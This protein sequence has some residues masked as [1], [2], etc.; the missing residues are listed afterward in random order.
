MIN[1]SIRVE[2][3]GQRVYYRVDSL[4]CAIQLLRVYHVFRA[5]KLTVFYKCVRT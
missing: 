1:Y 3:L 2:M 5:M 4:L